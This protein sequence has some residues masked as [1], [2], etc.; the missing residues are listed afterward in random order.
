MNFTPLEASVAK[1]LPVVALNGGEAAH[2]LPD[3]HN[4]SGVATPTTGQQV[5]ERQPMCERTISELVQLLEERE[6][7]QAKV[8]ERF[9]A[10]AR[11]PAGGGPL[12]LNLEDAERLARSLAAELR[13]APSFFGEISQ[14]FCRFD[15]NGDGNLDEDEGTELMLHMLYRYR[16][17]TSQPVPGRVLLGGTIRFANPREKFEFVQKIGHGSQG[18]VY[19]CRN[20][21]SRQEVCV[22]MYDKSNPN[23]PVEEITREFEILMNLKHPRIAHVFDIFQDEL[24]IYIVQEAYFGG[25]LRVLLQNAVN[26]GVK[27]NEPWIARIFQQ[28]LLGVAFLHKSRVI[29]CDLKEP[30]VMVTDRTDFHT[31][32]VVVIDFGLCNQFHS[33]SR[34]GGTPGY[35]PPEVWESGLWTP[36]GDVFS[37]GVMLFSL[38]TGS[39]PFT[40]GAQSL[41]QVIDRTHRVDLQMSPG[42]SGELQDLV[43][44]M[45]LKGPFLE[46]PTVE[47]AMQARWFSVDD[48]EAPAVH[49]DIL[50]ALAR[51]GEKR[52]VHRALFTDV[53]S[54]TNLAQLREL[55]EIFVGLDANNDG[56]VSADEVRQCLTD[57][58]TPEEIERLISVLVGSSEG[59][60]SYEQ[61]MGQLLAS[62]KPE[63]NELVQ[64]IFNEVDS[65]RKGYITADELAEL[66]KRPS[67]AQV[68]GSRQP[69]EVMKEMGV[70]RNDKVVFDDFRIAICGQDG[71]PGGAQWY[72]VGQELEYYSPVYCGWVPCTV[73]KV[74][75]RT[76]AVQVSAN[77]GLWV[78]GAEVRRRIRPASTKSTMANMASRLRSAKV[79]ALGRQLLAGGLDAASEGK[80][81]LKN[82]LSCS[83]VARSSQCPPSSS[84][85]CGT[86]GRLLQ[87]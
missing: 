18:S 61:F 38:R 54:K 76:G 26:S 37:I 68:L 16:D 51:Q 10:F 17:A 84:T 85:R 33:R 8:R 27:V 20:N 75:Q 15:F 47:E 45:T 35:M 2:S 69:E 28:I 25:D 39:H 40:D 63:E 7:L 29:H 30:N 11:C 36:R 49:T 48:K 44:L 5:E 73:T 65:D 43:G 12:H 34:P 71:P 1:A 59:E 80:D 74:D 31:P 62:K 32:Q 50:A 46:R 86:H 66:L 64:N 13:V 21:S 55:N 81:K 53:A 6:P 9:R 3:W 4:G 42:C 67:F 79:G 14:M 24:N 19:L 82:A 57:R 87:L 22:K 70:D 41:E 78:R 83:R 77:P 60:V 23:N 56:F 52:K 72:E 58:W